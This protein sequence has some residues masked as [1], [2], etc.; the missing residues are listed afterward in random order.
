MGE[1]EGGGGRGGGRMIDWRYG[2]DGGV[3]A[4]AC[5]HV[6][7]YAHARVCV[8][9]SHCSVLSGQVPPNQL[10]FCVCVCVLV[11]GIDINHRSSRG[12]LYA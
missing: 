8:K 6:R 5:V 10:P 3:K 11:G 1:E 2:G 4:S 9:L 12:P 7:A